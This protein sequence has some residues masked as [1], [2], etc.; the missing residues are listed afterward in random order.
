VDAIDIVMVTHDRLDYLVATVETLYDRTPE[1]FR[2]T[3][4]DN[5]SGPA[6]RNWL[7]EVRPCGPEL[8]RR[9]PRALRARARAAGERARRRVPA[10]NRRDDE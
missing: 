5:A 4:V 10:R 3:V 1:P 6:V 9:E 2:L 7:A 8:A